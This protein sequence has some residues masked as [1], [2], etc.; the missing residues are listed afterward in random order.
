MRVAA[1]CELRGDF[2]VQIE[3]SL[4]QAAG[5]FARCCER[6][7]KP[8]ETSKGVQDGG[9][10]NDDHGEVGVIEVVE[11]VDG[12]LDGIRAFVELLVPSVL[13]A[14]ETHLYGGMK[15]VVGDSVDISERAR[16]ICEPLAVYLR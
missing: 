8:V 3:M 16:T 9:S 2:T 10:D 5:A 6:G 1:P 7:R 11:F 4:G 15:P 12:V 14:V 13:G